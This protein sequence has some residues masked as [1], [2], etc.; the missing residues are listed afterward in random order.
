[1]KIGLIGYG[2]MGKEVEAL[3]QSRGHEIVTRITRESR[4]L[5]EL[6][7][8]DV[9]ID[10]SVPEKALTYV[11][12]AARLGKPLVVGTTGWEK[13]L[14]K[15]KSE[16]EGSHGALLFAPNFSIGIYLFQQIAREA[17][18]QI[19][20]TNKYQ[21]LGYELHHGEKKDAPSG[22]AKAIQNEFPSLTFSSMRSGYH[23]GTH[24]LIFDSL[25]DTIELTHRARNRK[26]FAKGALE[27][28]DWIIGKTGFFT[29]DYFIKDKVKWN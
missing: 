9:W 11:Q 24:Q 8:A 16:I 6:E 22:T 28:A 4:D 12:M 18:K 25:E 1:M 7:G 21:V 3:A 13:D 19:G 23:P 14:E 27:C 26:S 2:K 10:F 17:M 29:F 5:K 20:E 15:A